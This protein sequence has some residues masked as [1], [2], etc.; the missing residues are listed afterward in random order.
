MTTTTHSRDTW[1]LRESGDD[2]AVRERNR[3]LY[4]L[5]NGFIGVLGAREEDC[6]AVQSQLPAIYLNGVFETVPIR[7]HEKFPGFAPTTDTR[8]PTANPLPFGIRCDG[9]W[10]GNGAGV[11]LDQQRTLDLRTG[12]LRRCVR[13]RTA[14]GG[15]RDD[16][17][18]RF[19]GRGRA[20]LVSGRPPAPP[21][22]G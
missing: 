20:Q 13:W 12:V 14:A 3:A 2:A 7:Y 6:Y 19:R 15:T 21:S 18:G 1:C 5:G 22:R 10:L 11:L 16:H 4:T 17:T 9:E 8:P